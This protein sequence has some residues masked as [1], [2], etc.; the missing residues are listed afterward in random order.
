MKSCKLCK[1]SRHCNAL[2]GFCMLLPYLTVAVLA[3]AIGYLFVTQ[4]ILA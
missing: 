2:P 3:I 1:L 4:E